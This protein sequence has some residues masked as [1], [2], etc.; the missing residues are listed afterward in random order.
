MKVFIDTSAYIALIVASEV[1][2]RKVVKIFRDYLS[3]RA[4]FYT[5]D[6]VLDEL[7]TRLAYDQKPAV[8]RRSIQLLEQAIKKENLHVLRVEESA[9]A[10]AKQLFLKYLDQ[11]LSFTDAT[12]VSLFRA[13]RL[14]EVFTLDGDFRKLRIPVSALN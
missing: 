5:S 10:S 1:T 7:F 12:T 4:I 8:V 9:F 6:Y 14:D 11:R 13:Y 3:R 2:H